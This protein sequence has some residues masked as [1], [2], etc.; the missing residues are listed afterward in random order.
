MAGTQQGSSHASV[1]RAEN[2]EFMHVCAHITVCI[3]TQFRI[4]CL[5]INA[6]HGVQLFPSQSNEANVPKADL[7]LE[8]LIDGSPSSNSLLHGLCPHT[9]FLCVNADTW[10][11]SVFSTTG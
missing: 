7:I 11:L 3:F 2:R 6:T 10:L 4:P 9:H 1:V 8:S 5:G